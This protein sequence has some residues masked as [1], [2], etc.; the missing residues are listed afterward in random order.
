[1]K[2]V[3]EEFE[4]LPYLMGKHMIKVTMKPG[5]TRATKWEMK[6]ALMCPTCPL[7]E[8]E[9][10]TFLFRTPMEA[11]EEEE[12]GWGWFSY[13]S[14]RSVAL[15]NDIAFD[16]VTPDT[17]FVNAQEKYTIAVVLK[18]KEAT[19]EKIIGTQVCAM[20]ND[21]VTKYQID[22]QVIFPNIMTEE[23]MK[24]H[25]VSY[26]IIIYFKYLHYKFSEIMKII[27]LINFTL[28]LS[29]S[30]VLQPD[31]IQTIQIQYSFIQEF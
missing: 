3:V 19:K 2:P 4:L 23:I 31:N 17:T 18:T 7:T 12:S 9:K 25:F 10:Q 5:T 24:V 14:R 20:I 22:A 27:K 13:N 6:A 1:M 16:P 11:L 30:Q 15:S 29:F 28:T 26:G 8:T 21:A